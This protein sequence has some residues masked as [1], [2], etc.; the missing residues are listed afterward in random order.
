MK[1]NGKRLDREEGTKYLK[2]LGIVDDEGKDMEIPGS[3]NQSILDDI[4]KAL[5]EKGIDA[6]Y[7]AAMDVS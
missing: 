7:D 6:D 5:K 3:Y 4:V 2:D 1:V